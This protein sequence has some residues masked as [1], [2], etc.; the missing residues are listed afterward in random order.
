MCGICG[1]Y[2][3][4]T[5][6]PIEQELLEKMTRILH[7][8]GP[9]DEGFYINNNIGLGHRRLSIIDVSKGHQ[10]IFNEDRS[11]C[12][13]FN[14][15]IYNFPDVKETLIKK[16]HRFLTNTD[17]EVIV[18]LYEDKGDDFVVD[19]RGMFSIALWDEHNKKLILARD[20]LGKKPLYYFLDKD[21]LMF[22]SE[23]KSILQD[24]GVNREIDIEALDDYFTFLCVPGEKS[25][26][27]GIRKLLPGHILFCTPDGV[28]IKEYW[29]FNFEEDKGRDIDYYKDR[30]LE[31][32]YDAVKC[33]LISDVPLGAFLSG[34]IDSS[35][36]VSLMAGLIEQPVITSSIGFAEERFNELGYAKVVADYYN[37]KHYE[38]IVKPNALEVLS[39]LIWH[40]DEPFADASAIPTYYV[41]KTARDDVTVALSGDGGDEVFAGYRRYFYDLLENRLRVIPLSI[42]KYL[43]KPIAK[44]Y[45]K[46]DW[47][48]QF[49]RAKTLLTNITFSPELGYMNTRSV[50]RPPIKNKLYTQNLN[51]ELK[52]YNSFQ[53][54]EPYFERSKGWHP[55]SRIQ[56]VDTKTYL[57]DDIL[58][59][60]DRMSMAVS[61]EVRAP[62]LD[63]KLVEFVAAIPA[64]LKLR[65]IVSKYIFKES[66]KKLLP[67]EI[68][69]RK[70]MGFSIP[71][72]DW[73]KKDIKK[74][75]KETL[76]NSISQHRGYFNFEYVQK[77][78]R[79]HQNGVSDFTNNLWA[80]LLFEMWHQKYIDERLF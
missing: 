42:R 3:F 39:K 1:I 18:H 12:V 60:V 59:K 20:R 26:F 77:M 4:R 35:A 61:L 30:L 14:G 5:Q 11:I 58:T 22:A 45:P 9:D 19:L 15:E 43:I 23:I 74:M 33:R 71:L 70:K 6:K 17:T 65:G 72:G 36:I 63:H 44:C 34:G 48:P 68:L 8:R 49:L 7:H 54:L 51:S 28:S 73:L 66:I 46:A 62:L 79:Q 40:F 41:S 10:P 50:F 29:D 27:K 76:F 64:N 32:L 80:L 78:W 55:L 2:N 56:Y 53:V 57:A 13:I 38:H 25:I 16:G 75:A 24:R 21:R 31:L 52:G 67:E 69:N 47:L 37:T